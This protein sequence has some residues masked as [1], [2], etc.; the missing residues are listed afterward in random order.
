MKT[1]AC[2]TGLF[3]IGSVL[4]QS[5]PTPTE[6]LA[7]Y[8][9]LQ[10]SKIEQTSSLRAVTSPERWNAQKNEARRQL[11]DMMGLDPM[12]SKTPLNAQKTGL[13]E[14]DGFRVERIVFE[15]MP[16]L[17]VTANLYLPSDLKQP[18]PSILYVCG[19]SVMKKEGVSFGNKT[20]YHHHGVW[21]AKHGYVCLMV[22]T[23]QLGEIEG[24]HHGTHHLGKWWWQARGY[25]PAGV[26][27][28]NGIRAL[29]YL[30]T[31][32]EVDSTRFGVTGRSGG[33]A[34]SWWVAALDERVR[35]A[36]PTAG[37]TN[38][39]DH[40]VGNCIDGHCD[41][42]FFINTY[43]WD[44][45]RVAALVA[46]RPLLVCNTDKDPIFP[47]DGVVDVFRKVRSLYS[48]LNASKFLGLQIAEGPHKDV[49]PLNTGAFHWFERHLKGADPMATTA[50]AAV[51]V[52]QPEQLRVLLSTPVDEKN[53][54][55][56]KDFVSVAKTPQPPES[57]KA[58]EAMQKDWMSQLRSHVF[59]AW[60]E[61][62]KQAPEKIGS[63][64]HGTGMLH[65]Y[66]VKGEEPF[67][68]RL[69][70]F[71]PK[72]CEVPARVEGADL[73][74]MDEE[75]WRSFQTA[76][77]PALLRTGDPYIENSGGSDLS[78]SASEAKA[79]G[80]PRISLYG[81]PR[82]IGPLAWRQPK[83]TSI[84][85]RFALI[86]S[87]VDSARA[88]DICALLESARSMEVL[89]SVPIHLHA[90]KA[91]AVNAMY[92]S[93]FVE[94]ISQ[95]TLNAPEHTHM[96]AP[97]YLNVLRFIDCPQAAALS[98][99]RQPIKFVGV[100]RKRWNWTV[101]A[102]LRL[103]PRDCVTFVEQ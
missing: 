89:R 94:P 35:A 13:L 54:V 20:G 25:T 1:F 33:G 14:G 26:E 48:V 43:R 41:C 11:A 67:E 85:R 96:A 37:I 60:P 66:T 83:D 84:R 18:A 34:T 68:L 49:Q 73:H 27:A 39:R 93:L 3:C 91:M 69:Y 28:W 57:M 21:F 16:K 87:T 75:T 61:L 44:F 10:T 36:A 30:E 31:R 95:M 74:I 56:D 82:G 7:L 76:Y 32:P 58:W 72:G 65:A 80:Q 52:L 4:L 12:P 86:G 81:V 6:Q 9:E 70:A 62:V 64:P 50:D 59:A 102:A 8:W 79:T 55:I 17:Y 53:T 77:Q 22:D 15:S 45:D 101:E 42:M 103:G 38:L 5:A 97:I 24:E 71:V 92:A 90:S 78:A 23:L 100:D 46:P 99:F 51:K 63:A 19:H 40:L 2:V 47:L 88:W 29:D 98:A